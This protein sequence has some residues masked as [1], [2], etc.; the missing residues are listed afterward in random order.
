MGRNSHRE[1]AELAPARLEGIEA[2]RGKLLPVGELRGW[3]VED[4]KQASPRFDGGASASRVGRVESPRLVRSTPLV[5]LT[6]SHPR[7]RRN[8]QSQRY[9]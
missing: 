4:V 9:F 5:A 3:L 1:L 2:S 7:A 8:S 6:R